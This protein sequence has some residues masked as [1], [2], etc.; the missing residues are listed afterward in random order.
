MRA[1]SAAAGWSAAE[2]D[3]LPYIDVWLPAAFRTVLVVP[4]IVVQ[5]VRQHEVATSVAFARACAP[6]ESGA[7]Y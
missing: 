7:V 3:A 2:R 1:R 6:R 5:Q 4:Q